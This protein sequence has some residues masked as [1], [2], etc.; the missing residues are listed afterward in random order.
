MKAL[1][2]GVDQ[3]LMAGRF[4][5][6]LRRY[7]AVETTEKECQELLVSRL[8]ARGSS[9]LELVRRGICEQRDS[10]YLW[11]LRQAGVEFGDV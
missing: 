9:F 3:L 8:A 4:L 6:G 11:L 1:R 10:P 7:L 2:A 5:S